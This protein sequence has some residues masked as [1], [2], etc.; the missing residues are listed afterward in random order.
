MGAVEEHV[1]AQHSRLSDTPD[2]AVVK[3]HSNK[4]F[5]VLS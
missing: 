3:E 5:R 2:I 1:V 4:L